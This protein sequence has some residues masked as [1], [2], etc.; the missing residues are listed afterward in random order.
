[1]NGKFYT[2]LS[3]FNYFKKGNHKLFYAKITQTITQINP[4]CEKKTLPTILIP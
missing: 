1:M 3:G 2:F 4:L